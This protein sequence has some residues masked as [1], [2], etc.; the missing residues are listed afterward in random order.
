M[1]FIPT[2]QL[3]MKALARADREEHLRRTAAEREHYQRM[4][5]EKR[6][7]KQQG[8]TDFCASVLDGIVDLASLVC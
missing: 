5:E 4:Q 1:F 3:R 6:R 7:E 8:K 2:T